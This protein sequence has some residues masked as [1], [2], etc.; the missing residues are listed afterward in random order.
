MYKIVEPSVEKLHCATGATPLKYAEIDPD[1]VQ[2]S[3]QAAPICPFF[4]A[5]IYMRMIRTKQ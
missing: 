4:T 3:S 2:A 1:G 5:A